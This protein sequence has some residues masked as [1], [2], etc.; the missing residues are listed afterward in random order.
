MAPTLDADILIIGAGSAGCVLA[1]R[2]SADNRTKVLVLEAGGPDL[3]PYIH[4]PAGITKA[5][6]N[7]AH[8]WMILAEP[9]PS[10]GG[11]VDLWPAGKGL[12]GSSSIN[13]MLWVRG[14]HADYDRWEAMGNPGW[15]WAHM[16]PMFTRME[17]TSIG[18]ASL[19]GRDGRQVVETLRSQHRL[20]V[21]FIAAAQE[22]GLPFNP[23]YNGASQ[24]GVGHPQVSQ[25]CGR[26]FSA[27]R[28]YLPATRQRW[29]V[30]VRTGALVEKLL[31]EEGRC[32][33][34]RV[35]RGG[36]V[37]D[38]LAR[39]VILSAGAMN[40]PK[41]LMLSG[42]GPAAELKSH[43]IDVVLDRDQVGRNLQD[44]PNATVSVDVDV[45]TY[46]TQVNGPAR[47][48]H[49]LRW[50]LF[51]DGPATSPYPH[52]VAFMKSSPDEPEPDIQIMLGPFAFELTPEGIQ[53]YLKPAVTGVASLSYPRNSGVVRLRSA[54]PE[55]APVVDHALLDDPEDC[56]RL[57]AGARFLREVFRS[58]A[59]APHVIRERVPG[60]EVQ[61]EEDWDAYLRETTFLGYHP[62]GT[63]R[64][65]P[66]AGNV[67]DARLRVR[68]VEGLRIVDASVFPHHMSGNINADVMAVAERAADM[69][70]E[71]RAG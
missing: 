32:V 50:M 62:I 71:D 28:A 56:R 66:D 23:D 57:I 27:A 3:S 21:A 19:R 36:T 43:G 13:G 4:V 64:M 18:E 58:P 55:A 7:P 40:T 22:A 10:R 26:R 25:L 69:I 65:G 41:L 59:Y 46:N 2:L 70:L 31:I 30:E 15:G 68:G 52:A 34:A 54:D 35:R 39:E 17:R 8:D 60:P 16:A 9:D 11:K 12:G 38:V 67:V 29:N 20:G 49:A 53:P 48:W 5:V 33:G 14:S 37:S 51:R 1:D 45:P 44:H 6:G 42:V 24:E 61:A 63:A 47:L